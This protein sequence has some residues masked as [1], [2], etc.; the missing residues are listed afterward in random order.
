[1][2]HGIDQFGDVDPESTILLLGS[3]FSRLSEAEFD[4]LYGTEER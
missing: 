4:R 2:A 1:M 3:G